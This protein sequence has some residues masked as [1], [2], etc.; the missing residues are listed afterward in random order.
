MAHLSPRPLA[1]LLCLLPTA[2][3]AQDADLQRFARGV[4]GDLQAP[5]IRAN[6]EYCGL[7]GVSAEGQLVATRPRKGRRESCLPRDFPDLS[8]EVVASYHTHG[9]FAD[10]GGEVPSPE[11]VL[12]DAEEGIDGFVST[13]GGRFWFVDGARREVRLI[14]GEGCLPR[15]ARY[16]DTGLGNLPN[17]FTIEGLDAFLNE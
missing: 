3:L 10:I 4:L 11:D 5:S 14:C 7:I 12:G 15:D 17:R 6:R 8:V 16:D 2:G 13:P 9:A 1:G